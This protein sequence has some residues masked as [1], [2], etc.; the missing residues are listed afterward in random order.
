MVFPLVSWI[1]GIH[2][3]RLGL[4][5]SGRRRS[6]LKNLLNTIG[7]F[8]FLLGG[9]VCCVVLFRWVLAIGVSAVLVSSDGISQEGTNRFRGDDHGGGRSDFLA[10]GV[11]ITHQKAAVAAA[12]AVS[13]T[14]V[15]M[16]R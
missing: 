2:R 16:M 1:H 8:L 14:L 15:L 11:L 4:D 6:S 10:V 9:D 5:R 3:K 7:D 12:D 13:N